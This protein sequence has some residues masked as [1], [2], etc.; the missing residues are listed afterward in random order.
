MPDDGATKYRL[1]KMG[2]IVLDTDEYYNDD[3]KAW[4]HPGASVGGPA[5]DP[6]YTSHRI[7]RRV[8]VPENEQ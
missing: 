3:K 1:L 4:V 6:R 7:F 5:P 2:E 8:V